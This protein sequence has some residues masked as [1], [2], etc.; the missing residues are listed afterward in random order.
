[1]DQNVSYPKKWEAKVATMVHKAKADQ[2]WPLFEDFFGLHKWFPG[3]TTC[4]GIHGSNGEPG[5]IRYCSGF[6]IKQESCTNESNSK[7]SWSKERLVV[8]DR[9]QMTFTYEMVDCNIGYKSYVSTVKIVLGDEKRGG[10]A[11]EWWISLD[12]VVGWKL[13][14]LVKKYEVG[15]ELMVKK[16]EAAIFGSC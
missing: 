13:E 9:A 14:D 16:M 7:M 8:I 11:V 2:I 6:G 10:C 1:M 12:P 15:L 4:R 5:C 3:L